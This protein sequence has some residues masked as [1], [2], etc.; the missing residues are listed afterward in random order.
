[1]G[2]QC[3]TLTI[4]LPG[5]EPASAPAGPTLLT[6]TAEVIDAHQSNPT[7]AVEI[8]EDGNVLQPDIPTVR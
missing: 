5:P 8:G 3:R 6:Y 4:P 1:M 2:T 7:R